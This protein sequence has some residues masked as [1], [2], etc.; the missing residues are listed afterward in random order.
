MWRVSYVKFEQ[1]V[2][3]IIIP[4]ICREDVRAPDK[5]FARLLLTL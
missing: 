5:F 3:P 2:T 4:P 1:N